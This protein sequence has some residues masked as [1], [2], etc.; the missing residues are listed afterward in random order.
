V[1]IHTLAKTVIYWPGTILEYHMQR[2]RLEI[3]DFPN[4][5]LKAR[6]QVQYLHFFLIYYNKKWFLGIFNAT[7]YGHACVQNHTISP[8]KS[9]SEDCLAISVISGAKCSRIT[10]SPCPVIFYIHGGAYEFDSVH[11]FQPEIIAENFARHDLVFVL[12][13]YRV[14]VLGFWSL[15]TD[16][17]PGNYAIH[18]TFC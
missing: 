2:H 10:S 1:D 3:C 4:R 12:F 14:G 9:I 13:G 6:G 11:M 7:S 16:E 5:N 15:G 18:G 17:A 8:Q